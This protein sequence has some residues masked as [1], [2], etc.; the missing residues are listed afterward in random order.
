[1]ALFRF[2]NCA[3]LARGLLL[4]LV[5]VRT[6]TNVIPIRAKMEQYVQKLRTGLPLMLVCTIVCAKLGTKEQTVKKTL[7]NVIQIRANTEEH[8]LKH[9][10]GLFKPLV[11]ITVNAL[12]A[13]A[14]LIATITT[15]VTQIPV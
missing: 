6:L 1:M 7:M 4:F 10:T 8:A 3:H 11:C 9:R 5:S 2:V 13:I 15:H 14:A 12:M